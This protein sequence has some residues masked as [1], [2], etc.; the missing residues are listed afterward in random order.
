MYKEKRDEMNRLIIILKAT[1]F[2]NLQTQL[3][4]WSRRKTICQ[5][6]TKKGVLASKSSQVLI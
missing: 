4:I 6:N 5:K 1:I 3:I 2:Y